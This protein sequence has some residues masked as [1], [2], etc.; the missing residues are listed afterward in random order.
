MLNIK[1]LKIKSPIQSQP[2]LPSLRSQLEELKIKPVLVFCFPGKSFSSTFLKCWT[3]TI[4]YCMQHGI[5]FLMT[6]EYSSMVHFSRT[7]CLG[8][9]VLRG[10]SQIPFDGKIPYTHLMWIDSDIVWRPEFIGQLLLR[11]VDIV[12]GLYTHTD[13]DKFVAFKRCDIEFFKQHGCFESLTKRDVEK[14]ENLMQVEYTGMGFMMIKKGVF[15]TLEYP[16]FTSDLKSIGGDIQDIM[17]ED[18]SFCMKVK[19]RFT[20][21]ADPKVLVGHEK[22]VIVG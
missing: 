9:N 12:S 17:S 3:D 6:S 14:Q 11:N 18:A 19:D 10:K 15:E 8:A 16:W 4:H 5:D 7:K 13:S 21:F 22:T 2:Q 20:I 1:D